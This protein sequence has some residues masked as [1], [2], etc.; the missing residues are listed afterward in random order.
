MEE[1]EHRP[2]YMQPPLPDPLGAVS[3][4]PSHVR[5]VA[6][7]GC[8]LSAASPAPPKPQIRMQQD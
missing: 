7:P 5:S 3:L 6:Q 1:R 2:A 4:E 8:P